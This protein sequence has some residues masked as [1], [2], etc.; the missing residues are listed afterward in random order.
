[1]WHHFM[2]AACYW[3]SVPQLWDQCLLDADIYAVWESTTKQCTDIQSGAI[4]TWYNISYSTAIT[5]ANYKSDFELTIWHPTAHPHRRLMGSLLWGFWKKL[6][7]Y[8]SITL[9]HGI[10]HKSIEAWDNEGDPVSLMIINMQVGDHP[11]IC[12]TGSREGMVGLLTLH[13]L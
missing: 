1:M 9:Y 11:D 12:Y 13:D 10:Y 6:T 3:N 5:A 4:I 2:T 8:D 7:S